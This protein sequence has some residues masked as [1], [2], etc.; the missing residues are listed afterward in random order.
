MTEALTLTWKD[1]T[2]IERAV[3]TLDSYLRNLPRKSRIAKR[4]ELRV[5]LRAAAADVGA[6]EALRRL[7]NI[8]TMA[9]E[10]LVTEY[11]G[12][13]P[14][15]IVTTYFLFAAFF[16]MFWFLNVRIDAFKAG[17]IAASPNLTGTFHLTG[18]AYVFTKG[19]FIFNNGKVTEVGGT[20]LPLVYVCVAALAVLV[21]RLWRAIPALRQRSL[22][23][24][25]G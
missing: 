1:R 6:N 7:G 16:F 4:R 18:V 20:L 19:T 12:P 21:G 15:W 3:W 24:A 22:G 5:N 10:Y 14:S 8:R 17:A 9:A 2:R 11:G 25:N 23:A 13:G